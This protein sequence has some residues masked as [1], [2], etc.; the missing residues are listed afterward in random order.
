MKLLFYLIV[1]LK[2]NWN[3][4]TILQ[5]QFLMAENSKIYEEN[6]VEYMVQSMWVDRF[7]NQ[8]DIHAS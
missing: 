6:Y 5:G 1:K 4:I 7:S 3:S 8:S 2:L